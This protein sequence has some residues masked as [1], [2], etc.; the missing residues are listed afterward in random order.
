MADGVGLPVAVVGVAVLLAEF[1]AF[2]VAFNLLPMVPLDGGR[3][4]RSALW[5]LRGPAFAAAWVERVGVLVASTVI[6]FGAV[7]PFLGILPSQGLNGFSP[8]FIIMFEG[9][10]MLGLT[11]AYASAV[12]PRPR[13]SGEAIVGDLMEAPAPRDARAP[14]VS[15]ARFLQDA[16]SSLRSGTAAFPV[17]EDGRPVGVIS[18][19]LA[20]Q[21][22]ADQREA[23]QSPT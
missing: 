16:T 9:M 21:V 18:R 10:I 14:G 23:R 8:G 2:A 13:R 15:V 17:F 6:A 3:L 7:A 4:L 12:K 22:P 20:V 19:G 1:N 11:R 5:R